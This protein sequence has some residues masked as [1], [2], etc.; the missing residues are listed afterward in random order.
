[1]CLISVKFLPPNCSEH[2]AHHCNMCP[3]S[4]KFL[5][6]NCF[7]RQLDMFLILVKFLT[8]KLFNKLKSSLCAQYFLLLSF[9]PMPD[10]GQMSIFLINYNLCPCLFF[11]RWCVCMDHEDFEKLCATAFRIIAATHKE[12]CNCPCSFCDICN[13]L[14]YISISWLMEH[15]LCPGSR[16]FP[17]SSFKLFDWACIY[18]Q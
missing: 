2:F 8:P 10:F 6:P 12:N 5:P 7:A 16:R 14:S 15:L 13:A 3:I 18:N 4:V 9:C 17:T 11:Y 1:M